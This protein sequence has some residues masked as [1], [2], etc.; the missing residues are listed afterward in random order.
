MFRKYD[1]GEDIFFMNEDSQ[2][3]YGRGFDCIDCNGIK[4]VTSTAITIF[5]EDKK[6]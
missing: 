2:F 3:I 6:V 1:I 5:Q 4:K